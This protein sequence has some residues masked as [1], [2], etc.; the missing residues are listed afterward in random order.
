MR[1]ARVVWLGLLIS[2]TLTGC[3]HDRPVKSTSLFDR[4]GMGGPTGPDAVFIEYAVIERPAGNDTVNKKIWSMIDEMV[5]DS[6]TRVLLAENGLRAGVVGGLLPP[7]LESLVSNPKSETGHRQRRL[8]AN[9]PAAIQ[10]NGPVPMAEYQFRATMDS[11]PATAKFE[12]AKF[13]MNFTPAHGPDGHIKLH[14]VPEV[15]YNDKKYWLPTGAVGAGWMGKP[16]ERYNTLA[17]DINLSPRELLIIGSYYER[18]TCLGNGIFT[19]T[20]GTAKV[21]RVLIVRTGHL[22]QT[23]P[24][25]DASPGAGQDKVVP[26]VSQASLSSARATRP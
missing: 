24:G 1:R 18:G 8:Y 16:L 25:S 21:Q 9:N 20:Q 5:I 4:I 23:D 3:L 17:W 2:L 14:C 7:E 22:S 15:E 19:G 12:Q 6:E 13:S 26:L 10:L 11:K